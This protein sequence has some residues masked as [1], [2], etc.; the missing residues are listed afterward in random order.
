MC[1][2]VLLQEVGRGYHKEKAQIKL[3]TEPRGNPRLYELKKCGLN[4]KRKGRTAKGEET[5]L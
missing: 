5:L 1:Q 2:V 4:W 3:A